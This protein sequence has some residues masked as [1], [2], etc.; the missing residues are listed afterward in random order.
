M[1]SG[2]IHVKRLPSRPYPPDAGR[3]EGAAPE[4]LKMRSW[5]DTRC[6][7]SSSRLWT[8]LA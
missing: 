1:T 7:N 6:T 8:S 5:S 4:G 2:M 3:V